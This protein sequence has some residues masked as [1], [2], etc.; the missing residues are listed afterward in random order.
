MWVIYIKVGVFIIGHKGIQIGDANYYFTE[1][2]SLCFIFNIRPN[3]TSIH[4]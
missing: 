1:N 4:G 2:R 3:V